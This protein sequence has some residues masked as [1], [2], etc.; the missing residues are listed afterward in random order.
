MTSKR[1][2]D[3][4]ARWNVKK[5]LG[6]SLETFD[7]RVAAGLKHCSS[8]KAWKSNANF[9]I[10]RGRP[11]GLSSYCKACDKKKHAAK[12]LRRIAESPV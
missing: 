6:I 1:K 8:C 4:G 12:Y 5:H 2:N 11:S 7:Q 9:T 10:A 3:H